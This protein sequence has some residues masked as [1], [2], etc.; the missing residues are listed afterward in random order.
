MRAEGGFGLWGSLHALATISVA[1]ATAH[2][3]RP[4]VR[5]TRFLHVSVRANMMAKTGPPPVATASQRRPGRTGR[6]VSRSPQAGETAPQVVAAAPQQ[7]SD[8]HPSGC[9]PAE[10][11]AGTAHA[12]ACHD[13]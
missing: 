6:R 10:T 2:K 13:Q 5:S 3:V 9:R 1:A 7:S 11:P 4:E 12:H 8:P